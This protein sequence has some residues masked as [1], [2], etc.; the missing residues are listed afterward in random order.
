MFLEL[1]LL[2]KLKESFFLL[3]F[4][5]GVKC[6]GLDSVHIADIF[7]VKSKV[8]QMH[9]ISKISVKFGESPL[10]AIGAFSHLPSGGAVS[11]TIRMQIPPVSELFFKA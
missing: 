7:M 8:F 2:L 10:N 6:N 3:D 1:L 5:S 4:I 9:F 11:I